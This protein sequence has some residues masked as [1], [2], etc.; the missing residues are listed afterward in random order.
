MKEEKSNFTNE[1]FIIENNFYFIGLPDD[2]G[3]VTKEFTRSKFKF[4]K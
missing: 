4:S 3:E 2:T 1:K